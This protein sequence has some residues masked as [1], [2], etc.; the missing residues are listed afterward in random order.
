VAKVVDLREAAEDLVLVANEEMVEALKVRL[1]QGSRPVLEMAAKLHKM[2]LVAAKEGPDCAQK[3]FNPAPTRWSRR[4]GE[5]G[6]QAAGKVITTTKLQGAA[7]F[8]N[9]VRGL[10]F[11]EVRGALCVLY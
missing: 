6:D 9:V 7:T 8:R 2:S 11:Y 5:G 1:V 4:A 3:I 10:H